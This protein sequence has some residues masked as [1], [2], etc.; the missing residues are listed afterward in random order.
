MDDT[1]TYWFVSGPGGLCRHA[2]RP[3]IWPPEPTHNLDEAKEDAQHT[4]DLFT[5]PCTLVD[6][7][8]RVVASFTPSPVT[9]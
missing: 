8:F 6:N 7:R 3:R 5:A 1:A 4:A 9:V 2:M